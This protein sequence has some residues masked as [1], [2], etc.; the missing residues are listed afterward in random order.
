MA[1]CTNCGAELADGAAFCPHCGAQLQPPQTQAV[2]QRND[3][4]DGTAQPGS[5]QDANSA[6]MGGAPGSFPGPDGGG[7]GVVDRSNPQPAP[8]FTEAVKTCFSKYVDFS[9]RARRSEYWYWTLFTF[10]ASLVLGFVGN[11]LFGRP[12]TGVN[13]LQS[14]FSLAALLPGLAVLFR[15]LHD[16]G[17]SGIWAL[18]AFV[19]LVGWIVLLVFC[20]TDSV[21]NNEYGVSPKYPG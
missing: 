17:K 6:N 21:G 10:V 20:C 4:R 5:A 16:I 11:L 13:A 14:L 18:I 1:F 15:R 3:L 12:E 7:F 19:P 9:G 8:D 2:V